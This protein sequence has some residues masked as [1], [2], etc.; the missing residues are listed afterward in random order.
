MILKIL[1]LQ[2]VVRQHL[3]VQPAWRHGSVDRRYLC[4]L[5]LGCCCQWFK[6]LRLNPFDSLDPTLAGAGVTLQCKGC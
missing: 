3:K 2:T 5:S 4:S 1:G 6:K